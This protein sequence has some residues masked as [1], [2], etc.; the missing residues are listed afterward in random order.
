MPLEI[1][2]DVVSLAYQ[3][4]G[5]F[6]MEGQKVG[7]R[8]IDLLALRLGNDG[9]I[10]ERLHVE[11][12]ISTR[13]IGVLRDKP[14]LASGRDPVA[15]AEA[16]AKKKFHDPSV[17]KAVETAFKSKDYKRVFVHG[18]LSK[19][20]EPQ[21]CVLR[22]QGIEC[23][24]VGKLVREAQQGSMRNRLQR[25]VEIADLLLGSEDA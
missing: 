10:Q 24:H 20:A 25:A 8:E 16:F 5:Y 7:G 3:S 17:L 14:G 21:L 11:V 23:T 15:A 22:A 6:V 12:S 13:P 4:L 18:R 9:A 19:K 2:E 1:S